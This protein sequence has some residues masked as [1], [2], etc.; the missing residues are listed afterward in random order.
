M[1]KDVAV[2]SHSRFGTVEE[3]CVVDVNE[4]CDDSGGGDTTA[5]PPL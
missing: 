1:V 4:T 5:A 2:N 3:N